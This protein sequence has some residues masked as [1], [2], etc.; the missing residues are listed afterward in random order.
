MA[1]KNSWSFHHLFL[2]VNCQV[3]KTLFPF[4]HFLC[5]QNTAQ[6]SLVL[7]SVLFKKPQIIYIYISKHGIA[8]GINGFRTLEGVKETC[9]ECGWIIKCWGLQAKCSFPSPWK[10]CRIYCITPGNE[11][12][13]VNLWICLLHMSYSCRILVEVKGFT[14]WGYFSLFQL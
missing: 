14:C 2:H 8:E 6:Y 5:L 9:P 10:G 12:M 1:L 13:I 3:V 11:G 4:L 7:S